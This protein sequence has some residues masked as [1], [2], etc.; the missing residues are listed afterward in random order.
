MEAMPDA[1]LVALARGGDKDAF[2]LLVDRHRLMVE[3]VADGMV[4][5]A[6]VA[7]E[8]AQEAML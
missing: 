6:D 1:K 2:G 4:R 8:L 5:D 3:R 7:Q